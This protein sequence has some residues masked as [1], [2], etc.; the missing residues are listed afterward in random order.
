MGQWLP[1]GTDVSVH[2]M[3]AYHSP[4]NFRHPGRFAPER[5]LGGDVE[6]EHDRRDVHQPFSLGPRNCIGVGF[7]WHEMRLALGKLVFNFDFEL[8]EESR[9]WTRQKVFVLWEKRPLYVRV[10]PFVGEGKGL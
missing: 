1:A 5:W 4:A 6:Y 9:G 8:C 2:Q 7:A 10:R 3:A